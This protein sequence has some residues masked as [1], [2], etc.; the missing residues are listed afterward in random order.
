MWVVRNIGK[1]PVEHPQTG[2]TIK[3]IAVSE[4]H[5]FFTVRS[6]A[7]P[8]GVHASPVQMHLSP[9]MKMK[10]KLLIIAILCEKC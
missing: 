6:Q 1:Q 4:A 9:S 5:F 3:L 2:Q 7:K 8:V 10:E